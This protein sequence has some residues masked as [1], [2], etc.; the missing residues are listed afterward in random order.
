METINKLK[1]M[2]AGPGQP[3]P[4]MIYFQTLLEKGSLNKD[5]SLELVRPVL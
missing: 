2:E 5:E 3:K 4:I 1:S